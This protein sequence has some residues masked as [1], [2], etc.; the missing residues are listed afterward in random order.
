[1]R[2]GKALMGE[3][4]K[5]IGTEVKDVSKRHAGN[6]LACDSCLIHA[7]GRKFGNPW[8]GTFVSFPQFRG[9]EDVISITKERINGCMERSMNGK[10]LPLASEEMK[11]MTTY[12]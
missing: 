12:L 4:Y 10:K 1:M 2:K 3:T 9:C 11:L 8:V 6:N 7:D 5:H